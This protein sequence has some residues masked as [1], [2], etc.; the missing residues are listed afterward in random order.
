MNY[1]KWL[2]ACLLYLSIYLL[3]ISDH[4]R[5]G[6]A[7]RR[8]LPCLSV[9]LLPSPHGASY[10]YRPIGI[11]PNH[12]TIPILPDT[13]P[14]Q[15]TAPFSSP[16]TPPTHSFSYAPAYAQ[17]AADPSCKLVCSLVVAYTLMFVEELY[18]YLPQPATH[19]VLFFPGRLHSI[20]CPYVWILNL[21]CS[22]HFRITLFRLAIIIPDSPPC[23][24][25]SPLHT[26]SF[27]AI[28]I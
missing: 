16:P 18:S 3:F 21:H 25:F 27:P 28:F 1:T 14:G 2:T 5:A 9:L 26:H 4:Q 12:G 24:H 7:S 11:L 10:W 23:A 17:A 19:H 20:H 15:R 13:C 22:Y 6:A 8:F